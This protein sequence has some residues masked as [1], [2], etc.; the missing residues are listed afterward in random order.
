M[1]DTPKG[2][3]MEHISAVADSSLIVLKA[4]STEGKISDLEGWGLWLMGLSNYWVFSS[5]SGETAMIDIP[6]QLYKSM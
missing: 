1:K 6:R 4:H 5:F 3:I 2:T